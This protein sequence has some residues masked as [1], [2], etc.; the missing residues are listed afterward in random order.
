VDLPGAS[1]FGTGGN[2][3]FGRDGSHAEY[4]VVPAAVAVPIPKGISFEIAATLGL[5]FITAYAALVSAAGLCA[6]ETVLITGTT[7]AVGGIAVSIAASLGATVIGTARSASR[8]PP[9]GAMP[10]AHW[11]NLETDD[12]PAKAREVTGGHG[13]DV[14]FDL[15][16]GAMFEKCLGC[17]ARRGRQV[18]IASGPERRVTFDLIDFYHNESRLFGVDSLKLSFEETGPVLKKLSSGLESGAYPGPS[19]EERIEVFPLAE[20]V[21]VYRDLAEGRIRRKAVLAP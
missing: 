15:V 18:A 12:L 13:A 5:P 21:Q 6:G 7:G 16:G 17:L 19:K 4:V 2:L 1:V 11:I 9:P 14:V 10:V 8:I 3:G 20:G